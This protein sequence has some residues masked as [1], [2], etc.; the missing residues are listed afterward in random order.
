[1]QAVCSSPR[2]IAAAFNLIV[3]LCTNCPANLRL[4]A[5]VLIEMFYTDKDDALT[6]WEYFPPVGPRPVSGFVGLKNAGATCYMNSVI[7][8]LFMIEAVRDG[9]LAADGACPDPNE[10]FS[11][12]DREDDGGYQDEV[13]DDSKHRK[14][15]NVLILK[16]VQAI[17]AHLA[18]TRLQF[19]VPRGLWRHF[20]M[21]PGEPVNLRE[22][23]DAVEFYMR[24][25]DIADEALKAMG[26]EQKLTQILG[27][28]LSDQTICKDCP[29]R[30]S[31]E[32]AFCVV[33]VDIKNF[34]NLRDSLQEYVKGE[35]L[36]G[37][38]A[39]DC[40][41]CNKKVDTIKRLCLKTLPPVLVIQLKRFDFDYEKECAVKFNDYFEFPRDLDMEPYTV[42]GL[43]KIEGEAID[44]DPSDLED[45]S[46]RR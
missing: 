39:Y 2:T 44:F 37:S 30:Y 27:G 8:Q 34:S 17:F 22:Q 36:D 31:R 3:G 33:S 25:V 19:Y 45:T 42:A 23:Q 46:C 5:D 40:G 13:L 32:Q 1:M 10:D 21:M 14:E 11:G 41:K 7:Q 16:H 43:A 4:V 29:H 38:N 20:R 9:V 18:H 24:V 28:I 12:E 35:L 26:Y 15:Y 6:E